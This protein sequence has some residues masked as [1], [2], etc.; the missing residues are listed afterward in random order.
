MNY[1]IKIKGYLDPIEFMNSLCNEI[2]KKYGKDNCFI[3][4]DKNILKFSVTFEKDEENYEIT[5]EEKEE[6]K[7]LGIDYENM[8]DDDESNDLVIQVKLY[9]TPEIYALKFIHEKGN[10]N[11]FLDN[12][13][14]ISDLV[15]KIL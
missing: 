6:L 1:C 3:E 8:K 12:F 13:D 4:F 2:N 10:R 15:K 7:K 14:I 9:K 11:E 5:E